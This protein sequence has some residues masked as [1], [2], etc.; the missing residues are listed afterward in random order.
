MGSAFALGRSQKRARV[1]A[2][3]QYLGM[4]QRN[5]KEF[6]R[7]YVTF[8]E[9]WIHYYTPETKNQSKM[10]NGPGETRS[11]PWF[12][13]NNEKLNS[14]GCGK[15]SNERTDLKLSIRTDIR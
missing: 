11:F 12:S 14:T 3:E 6:L 10:W 2:S 8:D 13:F 15:F 1:V 5:S 7:R 9:T 4:F